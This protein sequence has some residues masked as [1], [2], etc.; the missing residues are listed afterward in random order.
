[1][2]R[3]KFLI[4]LGVVSPLVLSA[5]KKDEFPKTPTIISGYVIDEKEKAIKGFGMQF[6]GSTGGFNPKVLFDEKTLTDEKGYYYLEYLIPEGTVSL[7]FQATANADYSP[8]LYDYLCLYKGV[9]RKEYFL[10][11]GQKNDLN[12]KIT[13]V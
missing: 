3:R 1:M 11:T 10:N 8:V 5:C 7:T 13:K 9:Y 12:F 6:G 4:A 2:K